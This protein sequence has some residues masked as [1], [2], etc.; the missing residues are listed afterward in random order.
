MVKPWG[1]TIDY[2]T[3]VL[4]WCDAGLQVRGMSLWVCTFTFCGINFVEDNDTMSPIQVFCAKPKE[5]DPIKLVS[6]W[7]IS[8]S[9]ALKYIINNSVLK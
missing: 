6:L 8:V 2:E 4:Y 7:Q 5:V 1:L 3:H 9:I